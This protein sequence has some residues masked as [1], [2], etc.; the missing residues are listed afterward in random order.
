[1]SGTVPQQVYDAIKQLEAQNK[2]PFPATQAHVLVGSLNT[3]SGAF[4]FS[5]PTR[6][7]TDIVTIDGKPHPTSY[8]VGVVA[9]G[10]VFNLYL[11]FDVTDPAGPVLV[12]VDGVS[13]SAAAGARSVTVNLGRLDP[14]LA[15]PGAAILARVSCGSVTAEIRLAII[16]PPLVAAGAFTIP[17]VPTALVYAPPPG[18][19]GTNFAEYSNMNAV[20]SKISASVASGSSTKTATAY[21]TSDFV[22]KITG[23]IGALK[24]FAAA[25]ATAGATTEADATADAKDANDSADLLGAFITVVSAFLPDQTSNTTNAL[26]TTS[27]HDLQVTD[28]D[29]A[30]EGSTTGLGPGL[31][32]RF[33]YVR[34]VKVAWMI[35]DDALSVTLLGDDGIRAFPAQ[36]LLNDLQAV[37]GIEPIILHDP[38]RDLG[39]QER[40]AIH[41]IGAGAAVGPTTNLDLASIQALLRLDPFVGGGQ[42]VPDPVLAAPRFVANEPSGFAG[43]GSDANGDVFKV[44]HDMTTTDIA[45]T[46]TT[47]TTITDFKPGWVQA[48]FGDNIATEDQMIFTYT[49]IT[50]STQEQQQTATVTFFTN[51]QEPVFAVGLY[52]DRMFRSFAF[53]PP[54]PT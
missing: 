22:G 13:A 47:T 31:G 54:P 42:P 5:V 20:S 8:T 28:S 26:T 34:N 14:G 25:L 49:G 9:V 53:T 44:V 2:L 3:T 16:R 33:I 43:R 27:E 45:T 11:T 19:L 7:G 12:T 15:D 35:A 18:P 4:R 48:L 52:F 32:D 23:A 1:M 51:D 38:T 21:S 24:T 41:P 50:Q 29:I 30:T 6:T 40:L 10:A 17:V 46:V 39:T 36:D 37:S